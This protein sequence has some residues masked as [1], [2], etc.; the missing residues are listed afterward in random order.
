M[1]CVDAGTGSGWVTG[2]VGVAILSTLRDSDPKTAPAVVRTT[3]TS[4]TAIVSILVEIPLSSVAV[5]SV[6]SLIAH[7]AVTCC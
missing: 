2:C 7:E 3:A 1:P 6:A 5:K 4:S